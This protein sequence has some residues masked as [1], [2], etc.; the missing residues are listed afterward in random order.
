MKT[1]CIVPCGHKKIWGKNPNAGPVAARNIYIGVFA[2]KCQEYALTFYPSSY[3]I[4]SAKYGFLWPD[5]V[6]QGP[7]EVTFK[8]SSTNPISK[9]ELIEIAHQK[10]LFDFNQIIII[11]AGK[12]YVKI[13]EEIF[14]G[15][16][17]HKP[18]INC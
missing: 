16:K 9:K 2:K 3:C 11:I 12:E 18:L 5:D 15:K 17:I 7:Y 4:L 14:P 1:L 13:I 6:V 8:K 10:Y